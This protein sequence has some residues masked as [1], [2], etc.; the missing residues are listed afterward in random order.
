MSRL[1]RLKFKTDLAVMQYSP[2]VQQLMFGSRLS[3]VLVEYLIML[4]GII[5]ATEGL[6]QAAIDEANRRWLD[7]EEGCKGLAEYL[8][9]HKEEEVEHAQWL[10]EDMEAMGVSREQ[11][12]SRRPKAEVAAL[13]GS[14]YYWIHHYHP[15]MFLGYLLALEGYPMKAADLAHFKQVSGFP[16]EAF[17]TLALHA[18]LDI[19][20]LAELFQFLETCSLSDA[21]FDSIAT[22]S[23]SSCAYLSQALKSLESH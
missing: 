12:L 13:A 1:A 23:M 9:M 8:A 5:R 4:H 21:V 6:F 10:L 7:G 20:H 19:D 3:D 2:L 16:D 14:Q 11:V 22:S 15:A 17:R 18:D